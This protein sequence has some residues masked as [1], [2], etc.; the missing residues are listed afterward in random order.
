MQYYWTAT[1]KTFVHPSFKFNTIL[2][3]STALLQ[4][5]Q[6]ILRWQLDLNLKNSNKIFSLFFFLLKDALLKSICYH[7]GY[8]RIFYLR[9]LKVSILKNVGQLQIHTIRSWV[10][11][12][13]RIFL[14]L[15]LIQQSSSQVIDIKF[16]NSRDL[17]QKIYQLCCLRLSNNKKTLIGFQFFA[18][19]RL[20]Y[21][22]SKMYK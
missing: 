8:Y 7:I 5:F 9:V 1:L 13:L 3:N 11:Y 2:N 19:K 6:Y 4:R 18:T 15:W 21:V 22:Q 10:I 20:L 17:Y 16:L 14:S 12:F